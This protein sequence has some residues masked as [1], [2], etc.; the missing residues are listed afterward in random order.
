MYEYNAFLKMELTVI[1]QLNFTD[2]SNQT[3]NK[4]NYGILA[5]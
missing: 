5:Y 3:L 1:M 4:E 2:S